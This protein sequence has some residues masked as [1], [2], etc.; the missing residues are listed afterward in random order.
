MKWVAQ[1]RGLLLHF[2]ALFCSFQRGVGP[3][4]CDVLNELACSPSR[5]HCQNTNAA[6]VPLIDCLELR[7]ERFRPVFA[8]RLRNW[9]VADDEATALRA[10]K[11]R[12]SDGGGGSNV[13]VVTR[14]GDCYLGDG[15]LRVGASVR[16]SSGAVEGNLVARGAAVQPASVNDGNGGSPAVSPAAA[17]RELE[18]AQRH[19]GESRAAL[20][21]VVAARRAAEVHKRGA[22][23]TEGGL[24]AAQT[25]AM[26]EQRRAV[27]VG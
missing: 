19:V 5:G 17:A 27:A 15:E 2:F 8:T 11:G 26:D 14:I 12:G 1:E 6:L 9:F 3:V 22:A 20:A 7:D 23:N 18:A 25:S 13:N 10:S 21:V 24:E 4:T 16:A